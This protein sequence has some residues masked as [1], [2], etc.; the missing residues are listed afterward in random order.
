MILDSERGAN[1]I[2]IDLDE[3]GFTLFVAHISRD[4]NEVTCRGFNRKGLIN[5]NQL[6]LAVDSGQS[7][8][9]V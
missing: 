4:G 9:F 2:L 7:S 1:A 3:S 6:M 5:D 8:N